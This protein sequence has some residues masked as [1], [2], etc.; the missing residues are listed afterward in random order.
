M[1]VWGILI[2]SSAAVTF[3][4]HLGAEL[5]LFPGTDGPSLRNGFGL[6]LRMSHVL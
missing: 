3:P 2:Q 6:T 5:N 4:N 1:D